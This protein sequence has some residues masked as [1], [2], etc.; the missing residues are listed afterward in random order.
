MKQ[1]QRF[2]RLS[3]DSL[4]AHDEQMELDKILRAAPSARRIEILGAHP[5][6]GYRVQFEL[7]ADRI[8]EFILYAEA[9]GWRAVL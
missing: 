3:E 5:K 6:G 2:M 8:D 1:Y 9:Q 4:G 7:A